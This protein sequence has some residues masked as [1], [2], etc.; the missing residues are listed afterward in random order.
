M[1]KKLEKS[2]EGINRLTMG[3]YLKLNE[4]YKP[5]YEGLVAARRTYVDAAELATKDLK[6][7][8]GWRHIKKLAGEVN[9]PLDSKY[10]KDTNHN[11]NSKR[12]E[13]LEF[14]VVDLYNKLGEVMPSFPNIEEQ[15]NSI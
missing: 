1:K 6:F 11:K 8:I 3:Q 5:Q 10:A 2:D 15:T 13:R 9:L 12:I 14:M 7:P 4:W